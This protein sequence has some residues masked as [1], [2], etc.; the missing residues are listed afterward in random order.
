MIWLYLIPKA[1]IAIPITAW[2]IAT[3]NEVKYE[4]NCAMKESTSV[5]AKLIMKSELPM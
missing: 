2:L 1:I 3:S 5:V 4:N